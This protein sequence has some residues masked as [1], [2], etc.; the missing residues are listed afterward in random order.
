MLKSNL[1]QR[2]TGQLRSVFYIYLYLEITSLS[3]WKLIH[4]FV[5]RFRVPQE[6]HTDQGIQFQSRFI[7]EICRILDIAEDQ[8]NIISSSV[9]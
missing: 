9:K 1:L 5:N 8:N 3:G 6:L 2:E 4:K 7:N